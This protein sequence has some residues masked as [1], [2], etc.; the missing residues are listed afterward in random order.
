MSLKSKKKTKL[1]KPHH[2]LDCGKRHGMVVVVD[3]LWE[4]FKIGKSY[5][6]RKL[7][8]RPNFRE[9]LCFGCI[10][11]RIGRRLRLRDL[12][13]ARCNYG[14]VAFIWAR[15]VGLAKHHDEVFG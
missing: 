6:Q 4:Q 12:K 8:E 11:T 7:G 5:R 1:N 9:V 10:E 2:C 15:R 3:E 13:S 14:W